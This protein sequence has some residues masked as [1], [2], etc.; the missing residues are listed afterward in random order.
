[1]P[2]QPIATWTTPC[3]SRNVM[4]S[5]TRTRRQI[6]GLIPSSRSLE[7]AGKLAF[8][9]AFC[10]EVMRLKPVAPLHVVE[11]VC[12]VE[13]LGCLVP[14]GT[15]VM[16]LVRRL[17]TRDENFDD[18]LRFDPGR[19]LVPPEERRHV[20]DR[21]AFVPFGG[22]PRICPGRSLALLQIRTVLAMLC[23]NFELAPVRGG[24]EVGEHLACTM[25]PTNLAVFLKRRTQSRKVQGA[26]ASGGLDS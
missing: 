6:I 16:M 2:S 25:M 18:A 7:Q 13:L 19:W 3:S 17:A 9:D 10:N 5:G 24:G 20:H 1:M 14:K 8:L 15:P 26:Q 23:R 22:G 12:D 21:R 11:P 4:E